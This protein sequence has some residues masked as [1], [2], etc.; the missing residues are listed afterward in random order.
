M[1]QHLQQLKQKKNKE[2]QTKRQTNIYYKKIKPITQIHTKKNPENKIN[3]YRY[4]CMY[5]QKHTQ[6]RTTQHA[7]KKQQK[8]QQQKTTNICETHK[9][10]Q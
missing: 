4:T 9:E 5:K 10:K 3:I 1:K 7:K 2:T 8:T 6:K